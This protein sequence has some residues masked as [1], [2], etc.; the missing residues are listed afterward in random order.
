MAKQTRLE[1][2]MTE[3]MNK[4]RDLS[5]SD[6]TLDE[7]VEA[8]SNYW[9]MIKVAYQNAIANES[10]YME[11]ITQIKEKFSELLGHL[12]TGPK[13]HIW[14]QFFNQVAEDNDNKM[15]WDRFLDMYAATSSQYRVAMGKRKDDES[16]SNPSHQYS[17][18]GRSK[19]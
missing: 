8:S 7:L 13:G 16:D 5:D 14:Q 9:G 10:H 11:A 4:G 2:K 1:S 12:T 6:Y 3:I 19:E 17:A 15:S 18:T